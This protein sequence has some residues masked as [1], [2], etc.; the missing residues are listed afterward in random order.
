MLQIVCPL[1]PRN[2]LTC[3]SEEYLNA[4]QEIFRIILK[5]VLKHFDWA[6]NTISV[7]IYLPLK[8]Q[9]GLT[10]LTIFLSL[11]VSLTLLALILYHVQSIYELRAKRTLKLKFHHLSLEEFCLS[12]KKEYA[13]MFEMV[14][15]SSELLGFRTSSIVRILNDQKKNMTFRKLDLFPSSGEGRRL[16]CWV[17]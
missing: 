16:L 6:R 2:K 10:D 4:M 15:E 3:F 12:V 9:E 14:E 17:P 1:T 11:F 7:L 8:A 5:R 13:V